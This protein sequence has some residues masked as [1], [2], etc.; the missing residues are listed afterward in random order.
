MKTDTKIKATT[1]VIFFILLAIAY[2]LLSSGCKKDPTPEP[3]YDDI[4][5]VGYYT[6][7][8]RWGTTISV[9]RPDSFK[10]QLNI[11][12]GTSI[13]SYT[14][15]KYKGQEGYEFPISYKRL[16]FKIENGGV[17]IVGDTLQG[18]FFTKQ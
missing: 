6:N 9:T 17:S 7:I 3:R 18:W 1:V 12:T 10:L 2:I 4:V 8:D 5:P 13:Q 15:R 11:G 14:L 16:R